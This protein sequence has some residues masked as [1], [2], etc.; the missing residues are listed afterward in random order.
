MRLTR[1]PPLLHLR[2]RPAGHG[3]ARRCAA[4]WTSSSCATSTPSD[5]ELLARG[6]GRAAL[7]DAHG[8]LFVLNDR[9]DLAARRAP[10][11]CTSARTTWPSPQARAIVGPERARSAS[12]RTAP[13]RSTRA[14]GADYIGVGPVHATPTKPGRPAVGL[15]LVRYAA[16]ARE[17]AVLRDRRHRRRRRS[18]TRSPPARSARRRRARDQRGGRP[19]GRARATLRAAL[20]GGAPL[21]RRARQRESRAA[22]ALRG[23][24]ADEAARAEL[25]AA[26]R[27][28]SGRPR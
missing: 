26:A 11:A 24:A 4:A 18:P 2:D 3:R 14:T 16:D 6:R 19:G 27:P 7:C 25:R 9:P 1:R 23:E 5:D 21:G 12:R 10:T 17:R 22:R 28:A 13:T 8:A 20:G 15:E